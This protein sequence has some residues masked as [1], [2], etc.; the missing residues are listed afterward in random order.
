[1]KQKYAIISIVILC[2]LLYI[3][4]DFFVKW[5]GGGKLVMDLRWLAF[6]LLFVIGVCFDWL[7]DIRY[8]GLTFFTVFVLLYFILILAMLLFF[9]GRGTASSAEFAQMTVAMSM[10]ILLAKSVPVRNKR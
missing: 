10:P 5:L 4:G 6:S 2:V 1:M 3:F 9:Y 8:K 7:V